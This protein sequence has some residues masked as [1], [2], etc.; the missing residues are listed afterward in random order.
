M[1]EKNTSQ[2]S[3]KRPKSKD[4]GNAANATSEVN[5]K[6]KKE[7]KKDEKEFRTPRPKVRKPQK[8]ERPLTAVGAKIRARS[9]TPAKTIKTARGRVIRNPK[10]FT[11]EF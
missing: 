3:L 10:P 6:Q 1:S 9:K 2:K 8:K 4:D 11:L 7:M 5:G